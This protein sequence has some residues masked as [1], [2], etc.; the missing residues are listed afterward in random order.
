MDTMRG[1]RE[2]S[3]DPATIKLTTALTGSF[4][5]YL[6]AFTLPAN[7][8]KLYD[9]VHLDGRLLHDVG[10]P[11]YLRMVLAFLSLAFLYYWGIRVAPH[12]RS[13]SAWIPIIVGML[14]F[15]LVLFF[16]APFD[17]LDIYDN[18]FHGRILGIYGGN[19]FNQVIADFPRDPFFVY[20]PWKSSP[21]AYGPLWEILAGLT[22]RLAG[23]GFIANIVAFKLLPGIF[24]LASVGVLVVFLRRTAPDRAMTGAILLGWNPV[25]LYETWGNGHNDFAMAF[26]VLLAAIFIFRQRYSWAILSLVAGALVKF[27]P[28]LLIPAA[29]LVSYRSMDN[30]NHGI[31]LIIK[32]LVVGLLL[33]IVAYFPFWNGFE[34]TSISRH[35]Q[36]FTTS[37]PAVVYQGLIPLLGTIGSARLVS[38]ATLI[39]LTVYTLYQSFRVN[40]HDLSRDFASTAFYILAFYLMVACLWFQQWYSL[41]LIALAPLL[42]ER[43]RRFALMF[44]FW[45][46]CKQFIF[47]PLIVPLTTQ[48]PD[49][50]IWLEPLLTLSILGI[51]WIFALKIYR[52]SRTSTYIMGKE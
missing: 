32:S 48:Y 49:K 17:A 1:A 11:A 13:K 20:T 50:M 43:N 14:A 16:M 47:G 30:R 33:A 22:A 26:W 40:E 12:A 31:Y 7:L 5:I 18:I 27:I 4:F 15:I 45:V 24:H 44:G 36:M 2:H 34:F 8:L 21:S 10:F 28:V 25:V 37:I 19:P 41:W 9:R 46:L 23:N 38:V 39:L 51:P 42:P 3:I 35:M 29:L 6:L 52:L